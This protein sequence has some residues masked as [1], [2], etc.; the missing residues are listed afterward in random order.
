MLGNIQSWMQEALVSGVAE[1]GESEINRH[2]LPSGNLTAA[3]RLAIYQRGYYARLIA[4]LESQ[5]K[6]LKHALGEQ[7]FRDFAHEYLLHYPSHSPTLAHLGNRF[8]AF[9]EETRPDKD[10]EEKEEWIDF[11]VELARFEWDLYTVFDLPGDEGKAPVSPEIPDHLLQLQPCVL[12]HEYEFPVTQYYNAVAQ[13]LNPDIPPA[14]RVHVALVRTHFN[15]RVFALLEPQYAFLSA[16]RQGL[17]CTEAIQQTAAAFES[18]PEK[19][20]AAW[21]QWRPNW[22]ASGFF[23]GKHH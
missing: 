17:D 20:C 23:S 14:G 4:C 7:L 12:L 2:I 6:A 16:M 3:Q 15:T 9:L 1:G 10:S 19:V 22:I 21:L 13:E 11:M 5:F 18:S 8:A